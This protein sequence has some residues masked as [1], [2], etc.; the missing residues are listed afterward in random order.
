MKIKVF[1]WM[2]NKDRIQAAEQLKR[3]NWKGDEKC[4]LCGE[5]E[6]PSHVIFL[7]LVAKFVWCKIA[8]LCGWRE[9]PNCISDVNM[10]VGNL[11][12]RKK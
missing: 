7:C 6:T 10:I 9:I 4:K 12:D 1:M 5:V 11:G 2:V 3:K 8:C